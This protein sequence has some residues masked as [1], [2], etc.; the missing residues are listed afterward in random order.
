M[1]PFKI[2]GPN[3]PVGDTILGRGL[4]CMQ[5]RK[6]GIRRTEIKD[7]VRGWYSAKLKTGGMGK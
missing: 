1:E 2:G 4:L 6:V 5:Y 7:I 3:P